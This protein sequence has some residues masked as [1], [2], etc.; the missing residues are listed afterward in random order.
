MSKAKEMKKTERLS[1]L[2]KL[3]PWGHFVKENHK[4]AYKTEPGSHFVFGIGPWS[5]RL[6]A[7]EDLAQ[8]YFLTC[9]RKC[10]HPA[11]K[12]SFVTAKITLAHLAVKADTGSP[13]GAPDITNSC[14][15]LPNLPL[16]A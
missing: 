1:R 11:K 6:A 13:L 12:G 5:F 10:T 9:V 7:T 3:L 16:Q 2:S 14:S 4:S 15:E 8:N